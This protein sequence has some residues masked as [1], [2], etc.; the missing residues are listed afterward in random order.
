MQEIT[1]PETIQKLNDKYFNSSLV[2]NYIIEKTFGIDS[3]N[4]YMWEKK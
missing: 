4:K 1:D 3:K 2:A